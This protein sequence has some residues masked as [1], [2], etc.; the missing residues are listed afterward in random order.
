MLNTN[1]STLAYPPPYSRAIHYL[2]MYISHPIQKLSEL[3]LFHIKENYKKK[4]SVWQAATFMILKQRD[5]KKFQRQALQI[6]V[7]FH[8]WILHDRLSRVFKSLGAIVSIFFNQKKCKKRKC[9]TTYFPCFVIRHEYPLM[10]VLSARLAPGFV[11]KT[12]RN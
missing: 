9:R 7:L 6:F 8:C 1:K 11:R 4:Y 12:G 5:D 2:E 3:Q 10:I